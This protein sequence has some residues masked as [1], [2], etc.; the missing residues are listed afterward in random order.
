LA[1]I[2]SGLCFFLFIGFSVSAF[3]E[4]DRDALRGCRGCRRLSHRLDRFQGGR[5]LGEDGEELP[6]GHA[7][8]VY[9][10]NGIDFHYHN[11]PDK[12][13]AA[14][15]EAGWSTLG[16]VG[17]V[18]EDGYLFLTDRKAYTII[19][20]GVNVYPQEVEDLLVLHPSVADA[21]VFGVPNDDFGEEVKAVVQPAPGVTPSDA[22]ASE[23]I[24]Y[25]R[26]HLS[27]IKCPRSIDFE[28]ELPRHPTGKLYKRLLKDRYWK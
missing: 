23:L 12:T 22:L 7:G 4:L 15:N 24:G 1:T 13:R 6:T 2:C 9:F 10:A 25:C 20:G 14:R 26:E 3:A 5:P 16:D 19:T 17:Y 18:D 21:A 28:V 27:T 8:D 11:D